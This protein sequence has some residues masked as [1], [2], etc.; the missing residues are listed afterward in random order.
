MAQMEKDTLPENSFALSCLEYQ[1][2]KEI[3]IQLLKTRKAFEDRIA[4]EDL[5]G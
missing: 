1:T 5:K 3:R 4:P 2:L